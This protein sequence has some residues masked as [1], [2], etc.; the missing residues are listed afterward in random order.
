M[1]SYLL[2]ELAKRFQ[3]YFIEVATS[4]ARVK[5]KKA[6]KMDVVLDWNDE[7]QKILVELYNFFQLPIK[8]LWDPPIVD[9]EFIK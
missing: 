8:S 6:P 5:G 2:L 4:E 1:L 3:N 9:E 7:K